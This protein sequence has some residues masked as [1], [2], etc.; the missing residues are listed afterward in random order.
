[1]V[2]KRTLAQMIIGALIAVGP[3]CAEQSGAD[4][5]EPGGN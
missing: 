5:F 2:E 3:A 4:R 1:V